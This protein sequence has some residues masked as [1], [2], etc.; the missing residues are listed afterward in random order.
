MS[1][2]NDEAREL[3]LNLSI[4]QIQKLRKGECGRLPILDGTAKR[5]IA[6]KEDVFIEPIVNNLDL[7][8]DHEHDGEFCVYPSMLSKVHIESDSLREMKHHDEPNLMIL[9]LDWL[10]EKFG[11]VCIPT[12]DIQINEELNRN[13]FQDDREGKNG[14]TR[15]KIAIFLQNPQCIQ[16]NAIQNQLMYYA[17][18]YAE[19]DVLQG[20]NIKFTN[21]KDKNDDKKQEEEERKTITQQKMENIPFF[22]EDPVLL[23]IWE[24]NSSNNNNNNNNNDNNKLVK[25]V[26]HVHEAEIGYFISGIKFPN[27]NRIIENP[28]LIGINQFPF[29]SSL[30]RKDICL[31]QICRACENNMIEKERENWILPAYDLETEVLTFFH[32]EFPSSNLENNEEEAAEKKFNKYWVIKPAQE[33]RGFGISILNNKS[34]ILAAMNNRH[35]GGDKI[36]QLYIKNPLLFQGK[37]K[38][39]IR[40]IVIVIQFAPKLIAFMNRPLSYARIASEDFHSKNF[41]SKS[42]QLTVTKY[43]EKEEEEE[44]EDSIVFWNELKERCFNWNEN[45]IEPKA[46]NMMKQLL[47]GAGHFIGGNHAPPCQGAVYGIDWMVDDTYQPKLIEV[48]FCPDLSTP[49]TT[50]SSSSSSSLAIAIVH[51]LCGN[52]DYF[53]QS[54]TSWIPL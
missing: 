11:I 48:N 5:K 31:V 53:F 23:K 38:F 4:H 45:I 20:T 15:K 50:R 44:E 12:R 29:E 16:N 19:Y 26:K 32:Q 6:Y 43:L 36:A 54:S 3:M 33:A 30:V 42:S 17:S 39:D 8:T 21:N 18:Y 10:V 41:M 49:T 24:K 47:Q 35:L 34:S 14:L 2:T 46:I 9:K 13:I 7:W 1:V 28:K 37:R 27:D 25:V 22:I 40:S 51:G 52:Q